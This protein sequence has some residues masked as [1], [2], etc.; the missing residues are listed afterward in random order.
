MLT[1][2]WNWGDATS[3]DTSKSPSHTYAASG[4]YKVILTITTANGCKDTIS[5]TVVVYPQSVPSFTINNRTQCL[6]NN[7]FTYTSTS[8]ISSGTMT[9]G[10]D[11]G[12]ASTGSGSP[13]TKS[14][15]AAGVYQVVLTTTSN[16]G[17]TDTVSKW[18]IVNPQATPSFSV[19]TR[20]QCLTG[21]AFTFT[22]AST[23]SSGTLTYSWNYGDGSAATTST[24]GSR[25]YTAA[26]VYKVVLTTTSNNTCVDTISTWVTVYPQVSRSLTVTTPKQCLRN[27]SV[28]FTNG[29]TIA[30]PG[31]P[32][33]YS[34]DFGDTSGTSTSQSPT[35]SYKRVGI[36]K[37]V[38][39]MTTANGCTDTV[40]KWITIYP[41][42]TPSFS[43]NT[44]NQC[45]TGN[46][47]TFTNTSTIATGT[48][49]YSWNYGDG[50]AATTSTNG[51]RTYTAAG[52]YKVILTTTSNNTCTD[53]VSTFV[54]V[55]PQATR[56]ISLNNYKQCLRGNNFVA[57]NTST[58]TAPGNMLTWSWNWGDGTTQTSDTAKSPSHS[59]TAAGTYKVILT[60]TTANGCKDTI[61][62]TLIV[63]PQAAPGFTVN[64]RNQC[65]TG[66]AYTFTNTSTI[67]T[68]T[69]TYSWNYT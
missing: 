34:W 43:V 37:A 25:T 51:S 13:A 8:T 3:L 45:L 2:S 64:I 41:Q 58:I 14:Y 5:K 12:N 57:T 54:R 60:I 44:R 42:A 53:T 28:T 26:G 18:I 63:S 31:S 49:T 46:A 24:N 32:M 15:A 9:Y 47:Y 1:W 55:Y 17:C 65:L 48:L 67:A 21:N 16:N 35:Y 33:T 6:K 30:A 39:T 62:K 56:V 4:T 61:S 27:N 38:C 19:N 66:N 69:L 10:W 7:S 23:I 59:Y 11:Y 29:S 50:S 22:N 40:S 52:L 68:G 20:K 36:F